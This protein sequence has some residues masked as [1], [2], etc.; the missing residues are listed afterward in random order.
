MIVFASADRLF[1]ALK[2]VSAWS[3]WSSAAKSLAALP[4][5]RP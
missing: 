4:Y 5:A 3:A 1:C 2:V